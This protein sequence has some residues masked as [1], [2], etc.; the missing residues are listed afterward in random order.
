MEKR[1]NRPRRAKGFTLLELLIAVFILGI[2]LTTVYAAYSG[3]LTSI[4]DLDDDARA[5]RMA[6]TALDRLSRDLSSL[7]RFGDAFVLRGGESGAGSRSFGSLVFWSAAHL[8]F[9]ENE[10]SCAP[11][12]I[13][14]FVREDTDGGFTLWRSD[15]ASAA[16][17]PDADADGGVILCENVQA[18]HLKYF[19]AEG[20]E[21]ETWDTQSSAEG[22]K[23]R[24]PRRIQMDLLLVNKNNAEKPYRFTARV[25]LPVKK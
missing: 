1:L 8:S 13:A 9:D 25:F 16:P 18:F 3:V 5:Y 15:V 2:V 4:R 7:Q 17:Q 14:Y 10:P 19:D 11:A 24:P 6:Q 22:Q 23:G 21:S 20:R 12:M